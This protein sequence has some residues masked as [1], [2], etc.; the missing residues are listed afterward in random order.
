MEETVMGGDEEQ[1]F[2]DADVLQ[3]AGSASE[4]NAAESSDE[5]DEE[6]HVD[7]EDNELHRAGARCSRCGQIIDAA[8]IVQ[9]TAEGDTEHVQCPSVAPLN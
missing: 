5:H 6:S 4:W 3:G 9:L 7:V 8:A 1:R 2:D